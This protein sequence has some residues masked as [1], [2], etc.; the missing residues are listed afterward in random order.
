M[1]Y[2][3]IRNT[4]GSKLSLVALDQTAA[5]TVGFSIVG[6]ADLARYPVGVPPWPVAISDNLN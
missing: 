5:A 3:I 4:H 2:T 6:A 1:R